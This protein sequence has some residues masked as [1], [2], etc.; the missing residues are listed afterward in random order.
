M[1]GLLL[2]MLTVWLRCTN[3][4]PTWNILTGA[5]ESP[6]VGERL[7]AQ[8]LRDKYFP[9]TGRGVTH[10]YPT[11]QPSRSIT[12]GM[13]VSQLHLSSPYRVLFKENTSYIST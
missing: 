3:P 6:S 12:L 10:G 13:T 1:T 11:Q 4:P 7:L 9:Q 5:L 2:E 8:H